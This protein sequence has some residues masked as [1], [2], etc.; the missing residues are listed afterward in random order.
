[1][2][3]PNKV[4]K[5]MLGPGV[6]VPSIVKGKNAKDKDG[7]GILDKKDCQPKNIFRQD[8]LEVPGAWA[9]KAFG[10]Q[11][12]SIEGSSW[13]PKND[14]T[15]GY[16]LWEKIIHGRNNAYI[17]AEPKARGGK[18]VVIY[19]EQD[20]Y[21]LGTNE[22]MVNYNIMGTLVSLSQLNDMIK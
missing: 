14:F 10:G 4:I 21:K 17:L 2:F 3:D 20:R 13:L 7:D 11:W 8:I 9:H 15:K 6:N 22:S 12:R 5:K 19:F 16:K 18:W 1:M